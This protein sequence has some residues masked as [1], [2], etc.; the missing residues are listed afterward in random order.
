[1]YAQ[2]SLKKKVLQ[3]QLNSAQC[4]CGVNWLSMNSQQQNV[5]PNLLLLSGNF[6][7]FFSLS[8]MR[9]NTFK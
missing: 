4:K 5:V 6:F 2:F 8:A 7:F 3:V 1:M 9:W